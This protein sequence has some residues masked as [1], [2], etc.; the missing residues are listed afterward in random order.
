[1]QTNDLTLFVATADLLSITKAATKLDLSPAAASAAIK[2]L[3][4]EL[5]V[6]L[7]VRST[8]QLRI[9]E[10]G[11][12]FLSHCRS[13]LQSLDHAK[14]SL[15]EMRG[16]VA[17][18]LRLSVSSDLGRN[19]VLPWLDSI[20]DT[21]PKL[22][23]DL[24]ISDSVANLYQD[25]IDVALRYGQPEDS[26]MVAFKIADVQRVVCA[27]PDY[28]ARHGQ[29]ALPTELLEHNCLLYRLGTTQF[30]QWV[31]HSKADE[32]S[33]REIKVKV[34]GNHR[35]DD[36]EIVRRWCVAGKGV[37]LKSRLDMLRDLKQNRL[38]ELLP[39]Y[40]V[41]PTSLWLIC[42]NRQQVTPAIL[43]LRDELRIQC[44]KHLE[45]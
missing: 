7:F 13:A 29:P 10:E 3:E 12:R 19:V 22:S 4:R 33:S 27:S 45:P 18:K 1:M 5:G 41:S 32:P 14:A 40:V 30:D 31:F 21:H 39:D 38:V 28:I 36:S 34:R 44:K 24:T 6:E 9:T 42:P 11:E 35:C 15:L 20:M 43:L 25:R 26:S 17:G 23:L 37:A 8:R 16:E 2:R